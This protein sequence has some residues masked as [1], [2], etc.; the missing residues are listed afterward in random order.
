M[1]FERYLRRLGQVYYEAAISDFHPD[2]LRRMGGIFRLAG[3]DAERVRV[4]HNSVLGLQRRTQDRWTAARV[5]WNRHSQAIREQL[6]RRVS[7]TQAVWNHFRRNHTSPPT[8]AQVDEMLQLDMISGGRQ[9]SRWMVPTLQFRDRVA[10]GGRVM[11]DTFGAITTMGAL[12]ATADDWQNATPAEWDSALNAGEVGVVIGQMAGAHA[13]ARQVRADTQ[14]DARM[15][16][17][18]RGDGMTQ[19]PR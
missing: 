2:L 3:T 6:S 4:D 14:H 9:V 10:R 5:G 19:R 18:A 12:I 16:T 17:S 1:R 13:D 8:P 7:P 11:T 15:P